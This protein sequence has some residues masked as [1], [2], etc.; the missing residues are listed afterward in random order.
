MVA[1]GFVALPVSQQPAQAAPPG[2]AFDPG[3]IISD[4]VFYD[5][6]AMTLK[7]VEDFLDSRVQNC[8]ATDPAIDC[9][10]NYKQDIP[11]TPATGPKEVGPCKAIP[12]KANASAAE[13]IYL[14]SQA[15]GINPEVLIVTLQKEQGLVTSTRP[16]SYMYRAAMGFGCPDSDPAICG[17]VFV[18]LFNQVYRAAKQFRWYGNPEGSFTYWK[19]GRTISMRY[20]PKASC[21]STTFPLK[22]QATANLYYYTPYTPNKAALDN[23]YGTGDSCS[24]YGNRNFWRFYHDWFGS[25]I[26]GG[27]I[28]KAEGPETYLIV[29]NQKYLIS[30]RRLLNNIAPLGPL[31]T[32][33]QAYLDSFTTSGEAKQ[34]VRNRENQQV[35]LLVDGLRYQVDCSIIGQFGLNCGDAISLTGAQ[36]NV[37]IS[38][39]NLTRVVET[40]GVRYWIEGGSYRAVVGDLALRSVG[41]ESIPVTKLDVTKILGLTPGAPLASDLV[42]FGVASSSDLAMVHQGTAYRFSANLVSTLPLR[43][44]F[45]STSVSLQ[46]SALGAE[47]QTR[48]VRGFVSNNAGGSFVLTTQGKLPVTDIGNWTSDVAMLPDAAL[49]KIPDVT[50]TLVAPAVVTSKGN[51]LSYFVHQGERRIIQSS[52]MTGEFLDLMDQ[53][54]AIELPLSAINSIKNVGNAFAPG[55]LV[56]SKTS[57]QLFLVDDLTRKVRMPSEAQANAQIKSPIFTLEKTELDALATRTGFS[58]LKV[59]CNGAGY[60]LDGGILYPISSEALAQF[61]GKPYPLALSTCASFKIGK[62][63][64]QFLRDS[65]GKLFLVESG[66]K[67]RISNWTQFA[68]LRGDAPGFIQASNFFANAIPT[69]SRAPAT[70]QLASNAQIPTPEFGGLVFQGVVTEP[71]PTVTP[72]PTPKPTATASPKPTVTP[73]PSASA[74]ATPKPTVTASPSPTRS[75]TISYTVVSGDTLTSIARKFSVSTTSIAIA[76]GITNTNSLRIGQVLKIPPVASAPASSSS[77]TTSP[78]RPKTYTVKSGDTLSSIARSLGV[79]A[80]ELATLN[81]ITNPNLIRVGQVLKVPS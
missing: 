3:L 44:W 76:N 16:T 28:L 54:R 53:P 1:V 61:P 81:G 78:S 35:F 24:A 31:G 27:Y 67:R 72:T 63:V 55:V 73:K 65:S 41:G 11:E 47:N 8:R 46:I 51:K 56:R 19:P 48:L 15:C 33:S 77:G 37:F 49:S 64:G 80:T 40:N 66:V 25:P 38:G 30:D 52:N 18:G 34:I 42:L 13:V 10:K 59:G 58:T 2:S 74:T 23:L 14:I 57:S 20:N 21:G 26:G 71:K 70:F 36:I 50:G 79:S 12:A 43:T 9:L 5:F 17:K 75:A 62:P 22:S 32:I 68:A 60:L 39:G 45:E 6:G 4:S 29:D 69:G 7:Q